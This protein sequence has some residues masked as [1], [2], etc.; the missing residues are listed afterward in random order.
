MGSQKT[1]ISPKTIASLSPG[2]TVWDT[3][4]K[5][6]GA[7]CRSSGTTYIVKARIDRKQRWI[8]I[9]RDGPLT[10]AEARA[11]AKKMLAEIDSGQ[12]PTRTREAERYTPLFAEFARRWLKEHVGVKR[13]IN[14]QSSYKHVIDAYLVPALGKVRVDRID[15]SDALKIHSDLA[16][17]PYIANRTIAVL[18][19]MMT[20]AERLRYRPPHSNPCR[21]VER[22]KEKKRKR[23]LTRTELARLWAYL[24]EIEA[25][26]NP[27]VIAAI[28]LIL[29]TGMRREEVLSLKWA[30]VQFQNDCIKLADS[31]TG[32]RIVML[33][34]QARIVLERLP[35]HAGNP[36]VFAGRR[37]GCRLINISK[38]WREIR[39][40][41]SFPD[42][43]IHDL[44]HTVGSVLARTAPM[45]VVRDVLGHSELGTTN[46]YSH[47]ASDDVRSAVEAL[48]ELIAGET[49]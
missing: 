3:E 11:C 29:L 35:R 12:D 4:L 15:Q 27:H 42:V 14:T 49:P 39:S 13:K 25:S 46:D 9:G 26:E 19:A 7:R 48:G 16:D 10:A 41:L 32:S 22:Y 47:T 40:A 28:R 1:K 44:R 17:H 37:T 45:I 20:F 33:S 23:P 43:R 31:K 6:F 38:K 34:S 21:G 18:S 2:D 8:T 5:R 36:F 30:D 24:D